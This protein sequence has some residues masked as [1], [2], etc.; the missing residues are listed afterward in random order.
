M[1][2]LIPR[3]ESVHSLRHYETFDGLSIFAASSA[4]THSAHNAYTLGHMGDYTRVRRSD[5]HV[6]QTTVTADGELVFEVPMFGER[7]QLR[8]RPARSTGFFASD[9]KANLVLP[10]GMRFLTHPFS[11]CYVALWPFWSALEFHS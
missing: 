5:G 11:T 3:A 7:K 6:A 9:F 10:N 1:Q 4:Q 8:L 2:V